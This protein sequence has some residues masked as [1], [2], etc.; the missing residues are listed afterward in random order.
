[1]LYLFCLVFD[2]IATSQKHSIDE[3]LHLKMYNW[4]DTL[5]IKGQPKAQTETHPAAC[6]QSHLPP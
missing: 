5:P 1:M 4:P 6:Q 3:S 2:L